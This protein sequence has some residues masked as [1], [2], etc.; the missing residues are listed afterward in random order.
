MCGIVACTGERDVG[1][2]LDAIAHRGPDD[3]QTLRGNGVTLGHV[4]LAIQD[5]T[6]ASR[7]PYTDGPVTVVYNGELFNSMRVR[8]EVEEHDPGREWQ[9]TGD[10]EV[11]AAALSVLGASRALRLM[12]GMFSV[13]WTEDGSPGVLHAARDR[14][15]EIPLHLYRG[16]GGTVVASELKAIGALVPG[17][18]VPYVLDVAPGQW[19]RIGP[20]G[21]VRRYAPALATAAPDPDE[22]LE[23]ASP[24]LREALSTAVDRRMISDVPVCSLLSGGIDSAVIAYELSRRTPDLV[25]YTAVMDPRSR[26]LRCAR[27]T[28]SH[29]GVK[30]MEVP[31]ASPSPGDLARTVRS[32]ELPLKAQV[33]IGWACL[34]LAR[35]IR[36]DG[37]KVTFTGEG[38]DELWASY[39]FAYHGVA[40]KGWYAYRHG[41]VD[42]QARKNFARVNKSFMAHGV[43]GRLPFMDP[44]V[45]GLAL[46]LPQSAV[47]DGRSRPKAVLQRA[48]GDVLPSSVVH[49]SKVAFQDGMGMK[50]AAARAV[51]DPGRF[52]RAEFARA[53]G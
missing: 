48:Y 33:E 18:V 8:A 9:T 25:C 16:P 37:F 29:L 34:T 6:D 22:T 23:R 12:D 53:Y 2:A 38:S 35:A 28:A 10:T 15:G 24:R 1:P 21:S 42:E 40:R 13:V 11:V 4:R 19:W 5:P 27:E 49:R 17:R 41:L 47:A 46:S 14:R 43:E 30:L 50:D 51:A 52:Y 32:I 45:T 26:D 36:S 20:D 44:G 3:V 39:G 7:Q 31:V